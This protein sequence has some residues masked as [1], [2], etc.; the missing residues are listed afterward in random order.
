M[1][2]V[3]QFLAILAL[4]AMWSPSFLFIKYAVE[5]L[6]PMGLV[7]GRVSLAAILLLL[8]L[9]FRK[10]ALPREFSFWKHMFGMAFFS[11][12][13]P[14]C[15]FSFAGKRI[16]SSISAMINATSPIFTA[17]FSHLF[18]PGDQIS[19]SKA[20]GISLSLMGLFWLLGPGDCFQTPK[21]YEGV[22]AAC[23][24]ASSYGISHV[25]AK[26]FVVGRAPFVAPAAQMIASS[27]TLLPLVAFYEGFDQF[28]VASSTSLLSVVALAFFGTFLAFSLYYRL[29]EYCGATSISM[30]TCFFPIGSM[31]LGALFLNEHITL[32]KVMAAALILTGGMIVN[33]VIT[34]RSKKV[35]A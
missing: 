31:L 22:V 4:T 14:F 2:P 26:K 11:S 1:S 35:R 29:L 9:R 20:V 5:S 33:K 12:V 15:L 34:F 28:F 16:D 32:E 25:Y 27:I 7:W 13:F 23:L 18:L 30:V 6:S 8:M 17:I 3:Q 19:S 21:M 10:Q 24:A